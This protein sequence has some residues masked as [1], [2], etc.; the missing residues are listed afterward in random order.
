MPW[1][2]ADKIQ[3]D[4]LVAEVESLSAQILTLTTSLNA[5]E[6]KFN[7]EISKL[8][9]QLDKQREKL[10]SSKADSEALTKIQAELEGV[11]D[12]MESKDRKHRIE[13]DRLARESP[14]GAVCSDRP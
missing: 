11:K 7:V 3:K 5:S 12:E 10:T 4:T 14:T 9:N 8:E 1:Q 13:L 6:T 2:S